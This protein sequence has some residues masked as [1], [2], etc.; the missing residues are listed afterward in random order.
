MKPSLKEHPLAREMT[1]NSFIKLVFQLFCKMQKKQGRSENRTFSRMLHS[2]Q[3]I[4]RAQLLAC[5]RVNSSPSANT[6]EV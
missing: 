1:V 3:R 5:L 6:E 4:E 2:S